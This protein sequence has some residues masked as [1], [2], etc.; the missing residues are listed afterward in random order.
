MSQ[1]AIEDGDD[2]LRAELN[3]SG[4][5]L[6]A[7]SERVDNLEIALQSSRRIG[8]AIGILMASNGVSETDAFGC[9]VQASQQRNRKLAQVAEDV[10]ATGH[11]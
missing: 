5:N 2:S 3:R 10:V 6:R 7:A 8:M 11:L 1:G 9:L 4:R